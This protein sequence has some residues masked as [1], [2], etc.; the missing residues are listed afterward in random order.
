[1]ARFSLDNKIGLWLARKRSIGLKLRLKRK[2]WLEELSVLEMIET[3]DALP[4][5]YE[6]SSSFDCFEHRRAPPDSLRVLKY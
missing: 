6:K 3:F 4:M 1:M 2:C 5:A